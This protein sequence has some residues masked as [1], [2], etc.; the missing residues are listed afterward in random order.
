MKKSIIALAAGAVLL[1]M[2]LLA[3]SDHIDVTRLMN[4]VT[5]LWVDDVKEITVAKS[6]ASADGYDTMKVEYLDGT[7]EAIPMA[8]IQ[9][10]NY[11]RGLKESSLQ[12]NLEPHHRCVTINVTSPEPDVYWSFGALPLEY[13][14]GLSE[15]EYSGF[16]QEYELSLIESY[17][18]YYERPA[19]SY[20]TE[21]F[22]S[23]TGDGSITWFPATTDEWLKMPGKD[24]IGYAFQAKFENGEAVFEH[25]VVWHPFTA[26]KINVV[27]VPYEIEVSLTANSLTANVK[28]PDDEPFCVFIHE[29]ADIDPE[30]I[31]ARA[32]AD[33]SALEQMVYNYGGGDW[34]AV[35]HRGECTELSGRLC[36]G[37]TYYVIAAG[38]EYGE[39]TS[40]AVLAG[41]FTIPYP[42]VTDDCTFDVEVVS[43]NPSEVDL[44]VTPSNPDTHYIAYL[45]SEG[46]VKGDPR[47]FFT[48]IMYMKKSYGTDINID[49]AGN[50]R[51]VYSGEA[52]LNGVDN[53]FEGELLQSG[54]GYTYYIMGIDEEGLPRTEIKEVH[55]TPAASENRMSL[56]L[57][58]DLENFDLSP[59]AYYRYLW[60]DVTP[61]DDNSPYVFDYLEYDESVLSMTDEQIVNKYI[62]DQYG[63]V[64]THTGKQKLYVS[65]SNLLG[66]EPRF[67]IAFGYEGSATSEL[68]LYKFDPET[69]ELTPIRVPEQ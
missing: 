48:R 55:H 3:G 39:L 53:V 24:Y 15:H 66:W 36:S 52:T 26:K 19:T 34:D 23:Y 57:D 61:S 41:P 64:K 18:D 5:T 44:K 1:P 56:K 20:K 31:D 10:M 42:E 7:S 27:D 33:I 32:A 40:H 4:H 12:V 45:T 17:I 63:Y 43:K 13:F 8:E 11:W 28:S 65:F 60:C 50:T 9:G 6:D 35:T 14:E 37:D 46:Y 51:Y 38:C 69:A 49:P 22:F 29:A 67:V 62:A 54:Q 47:E 25:D 59:N 21:D 30:S 68:H 16:I 2:T 58:F